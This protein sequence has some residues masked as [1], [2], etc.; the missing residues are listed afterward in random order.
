LR[1]RLE[2]FV[3][4]RMSSKLTATFSGRRAVSDVASIHPTQSRSSR[5]EET[6]GLTADF[7]YALTPRTSIQQNYGFSTLFTSF[8]FDAPRDNIQRTR[9]V[10]TTVSAS[11]TPK[12]SLQLQHT[13]K[14]RESGGYRRE[15]SIRVF[16]RGDI[17][18]DQDLRASLSY[19]I[20][21]WLSFRTEE[22]L[23][24]DDTVRLVTDR[25]APNSRIDLTQS[26]SL[27]R[28]LPGG[29]TLAAN[30]DLRLQ[31]I[32]KPGSSYA[33]PIFYANVKVD[34]SF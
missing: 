8:Q 26:A 2:G 5:L 23:H 3:T 18:Y 16:A 27:S 25:H 28:T 11:V 6:Y 14:F 7:K 29:G 4:Y 9:D 24:R 34:K 12:V 19:Q 30:A 33:D 31:R 13:Y 22:W 10:R 21:N 17:R 15:R 32:L 20:T 1:N